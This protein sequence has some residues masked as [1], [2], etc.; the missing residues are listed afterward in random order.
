MNWSL[1]ITNK[2]HALLHQRAD[3]DVVRVPSVGSNEAAAAALLHAHDHLVDDLGHVRLEHERLLNLVQQALRL[4]EGTAVE[5]DVEAAGADLLETLDHVSVLGE[6][7]RLDA[8]LFL[9]E[10][11]TLGDAVNADDALGALEFGPLGYALTDGTETL[12]RALEKPR[13]DIEYRTY[14]NADRITFVD[15]GIHDAVVAR[16]KDVGQI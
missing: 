7:E 3:V 5:R 15:T 14:P 4:V 11:E 2:T 13:H 6:V 16:W 9:S 1:A 12:N 10:S 8:A